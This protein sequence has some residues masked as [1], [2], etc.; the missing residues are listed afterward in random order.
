[1]LF[2]FEGVFSYPDN[3]D[4]FIAIPSME[5]MQQNI[6]VALD[7]LEKEVKFS[8]I[9]KDKDSLKVQGKLKISK[10]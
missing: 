7:N 8:W 2:N 9:E 6:V 10:L 5:K 3:Q 1:M 4:L